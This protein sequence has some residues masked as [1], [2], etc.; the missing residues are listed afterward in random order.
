MVAASKVR[1]GGQLYDS[2]SNGSGGAKAEEDSSLVG[3]LVAWLS[4]PAAFLLGLYGTALPMLAGLLLGGAGTLRALA[5]QRDAWNAMRHLGHKALDAGLIPDVLTRLAIRRFCA[6]KAAEL[7]AEAPGVEASMVCARL[8]KRGLTV[9]RAPPASGPRS[10]HRPRARARAQARTMAFAEE[11][12]GMPIAVHTAAANEQHYEVSAAFYDICLGKARHRS[13]LRLRS[14]LLALP[15]APAGSQPSQPAPHTHA[16][17]HL[18]SARR[19]FPQ[20]RAASTRAASSRRAPI[21]PTR[22]SCCR[23]RSSTRS[24]R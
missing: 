6:Q 24:T 11:L 15:R 8:R 1:G 2:D 19:A 23:R 5:K 14:P 7:E 9:A 4:A 13:L 21:R 20:A 16:H 10:A 17:A 18:L 12:R 3:Q 22:P